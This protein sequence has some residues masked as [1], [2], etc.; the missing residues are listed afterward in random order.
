MV[1]HSGSNQETKKIAADLAS[2]FK[3]QGKII[4]LTGELGAGKTTLVQGVAQ[5]LGIKDKIISPTFVL[6]RQHSHNGNKTLYHVDLYRLS[7]NPNIEE[8]GLRDLFSG[9]DDFVLIEWA[10]KIKDKLPKKTI[11]IDIKKTSEHGRTIQISDTLP[12]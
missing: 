6:M 3:G 7:D 12:E 4:A 11:F 5:G 10:D 8:L 2:S 1:F 9:N